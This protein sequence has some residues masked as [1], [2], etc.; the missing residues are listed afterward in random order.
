MGTA[1]FKIAPEASKEI[2]NGSE[3][4]P[5]KVGACIEARLTPVSHS[6]AA[7]HEKA[8]GVPGKV[9]GKASGGI[10]GTDS[11]LSANYWS[12]KKWSC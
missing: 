6:A 10:K 11:K 8:A 9:S 1:P 4:V 2:P 3:G 5:A 12:R 7:I